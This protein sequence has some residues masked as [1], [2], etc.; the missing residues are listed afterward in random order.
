[1]VGLGYTVHLL[2]IITLENL[3]V[4]LLLAFLAFFF[5]LWVQITFSKRNFILA[6]FEIERIF[7]LYFIHPYM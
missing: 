2:L 3:K 4:K 5:S 1:L 6:L 7:R